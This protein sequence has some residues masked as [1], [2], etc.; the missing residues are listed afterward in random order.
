MTAR[1]PR[2]DE[3]GVGAF[4]SLLGALVILTMILVATHV[5][6]ALQR[7]TVVDS[8]AFDV[9]R[10]VAVDGGMSTA[11]AEGRARALLHDPNAELAWR[12]GSDG[13]VELRVS[14][15][16]PNVIGVGPLRSLATIVRTVHVRRERLQDGSTGR[17]AS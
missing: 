14:T 5:L 15:R 10:R 6:L 16:S 2:S 8:V 9:A 7:R 13:A 3:D 11:E 12:V 1:R 17:I 4:N